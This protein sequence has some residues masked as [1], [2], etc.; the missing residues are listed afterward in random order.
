MN[1]LLLLVA[2]FG[3]AAG[4]SNSGGVSLSSEEHS[5]KRCII[6]PAGTTNCTGTTGQNCSDSTY[7]AV[8]SSLF[9]WLTVLFCSDAQQNVAGDVFQK[10]VNRT[11]SN[12]PKIDWTSQ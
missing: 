12:H 8:R 10:F 4:H 5:S 6:A 11:K 3:F 2:L 9:I 1:S 7:L